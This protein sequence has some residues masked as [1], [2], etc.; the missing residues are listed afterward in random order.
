VSYASPTDQPDILL[1]MVDQMRFPR[2]LNTS[3][4]TQVQGITPNINTIFLQS[5]VF[6]NYHVVASPCTPSRAAIL[7]GLY[8]QQTCMFANQD[9]SAP[10]LLPYNPAWT[11]GSG[12][13][14]FPTI[15]NVLSQSI[16]N[17]AETPVYTS[18]DCA[19]IGK[20]HVSDNGTGGGAGPDG[21]Q[22][23]GFTNKYSIPNPPE[24]SGYST[25][26]PSPNGSVNEA[27]GGNFLLASEG[28]ADSLYTSP[29]FPTGSLPISPLSYSQL[30]DAAIYQAFEHYWLPNEM[31][32]PGTH[33]PVEPWFCAVS[34]VNSHD[35]SR[36]PWAFALAGSTG[37]T[38]AFPTIPSDPDTAGYL[39]PPTSGVSASCGPPY[40]CAGTTIYPQV[41]VFS[42]PS[43]LPPAGNWNADDPS[44]QPYLHGD[45][46]VE[47]TGKP[48][49]QAYFQADFN[50]SC[51]EIET[52]GGWAQFLNYYY[53][54]QDAWTC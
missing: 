3:Q 47:P 32:N 21:P 24:G 49:L 48:G 50:N 38:G 11:A 2:W 16:P 36:F 7:T 23:Y 27:N 15:G 20:W 43:N 42:S 29:S 39:P 53:W 26:Y 18:Y 40:P 19:W 37:S 10:A 8:P 33:Q 45:N 51:G 12:Q 9:G 44:L 4:W 52:Q 25:T 1:I 22:D 28:L 35:I 14:G 5:F 30:N 41:T 46:C 17:T 54:M 31:S 6:P 13:P 34:F